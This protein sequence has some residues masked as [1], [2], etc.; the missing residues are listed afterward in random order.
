MAAAPLPPLIEIN[1][2][3][4][5]DAA[6]TEREMQKVPVVRDPACKSRCVAAIVDS[7]HKVV[8]SSFDGRPLEPYEPLKEGDYVLLTAREPERS[9]F[10]QKAS[11]LLFGEARPDRAEIIRHLIAGGRLD[12]FIV[13]KAEL[14]GD[15]QFLSNAFLPTL[16]HTFEVTG[17][18]EAAASR[19]PRALTTN[20]A[21]AYPSAPV[22]QS[23]RPAPRDVLTLRSLPED[24]VL[25][26]GELSR[27]RDLALGP[28][29]RGLYSAALYRVEGET[30]TLVALAHFIVEPR[31]P[32][33]AA[34]AAASAIRASPEEEAVMNALR[35]TA[36]AP[37]APPARSA[38]A[39]RAARGAEGMASTLGA[40][41]S[42]PSALYEPPPPAYTSE[43]KP[44]P[45][46]AVRPPAYAPPPYMPLSPTEPHPRAPGGP[47][48]ALSFSQPSS[49]LARSA[50]QPPRIM[51]PV[52][53]FFEPP[54]L[55]RPPPPLLPMPVPVSAKPELFGAARALPEPGLSIAASALPEPE[56]S[57]A[58][59][60]PSEATLRSMLLE[61]GEVPPRRR[62]NLRPRAARSPE[63]RGA[64][65]LET[66]PR[67]R[68]QRRL[69]PTTASAAALAP[70]LNAEAQALAPVAP[71]ALAP[72]PYVREEAAPIA[73][74][75]LAPAPYG[76]EEAAPI[77]P[78][79]P[80]PYGGEEAAPMAPF[81]PAVASYGGGAAAPFAIG[82]APEPVP[83]TSPQAATA[84][85]RRRR[86][87]AARQRLA[88]A[89]PAELALAEPQLPIAPSVPQR[90]PSR[91]R[92]TPALKNDLSP[93]VASI[94]AAQEP[95]Q[96]APAALPRR[97]V[98][99]PAFASNIDP[100][101]LA[102]AELAPVSEARLPGSASAWPPGQQFAFSTPAQSRRAFTRKGA[103]TAPPS[104]ARR[105]A[106]AA[107]SQAPRGYFTPLGARTLDE[108]SQAYCRCQAHVAARQ[109]TWCLENVNSRAGQTSP[110]GRKCYN[111]FAICHA[112]VRGGGNECSA[113][114]N[115]EGMPT[116]ELWAYAALRRGTE[117]RLPP[118]EDAEK[119][120]AYLVSLMRSIASK[121]T[122]P[123][124]TQQS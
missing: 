104:W 10:L 19:V 46:E 56:L 71:F 81:A 4:A 122:R 2:W 29:R 21:F 107:M 41:P 25:Y 120:R 91:P 87:A 82:A 108:R 74:F 44:M 93:F 105:P 15:G 55:S 99:R 90:R 38:A 32:P 112:S 106:V 103:D 14:L 115:W 48:S 52:A 60:A 22:L 28:G 102:A 101:A 109:D 70:S 23:E 57:G 119:H 77:A 98:R 33:S 116:D 78:F 3:P 61:V 85:R 72:A 12:S 97:R 64:T 86:A 5:H 59:S 76:R 88:E 47:F 11:D 111:P 110:D 43:I 36:H 62:R 118:R 113:Y 1:G 7:N 79:A 83:F 17:L 34:A 49:T 42:A 20:A 54:L 63:P 39:Q 95:A 8:F 26:N 37:S 51:A 9:S 6:F 65:T 45:A 94:P 66:E 92:Y 18:S 27:A 24:K 53:R 75:A 58:A 121:R 69:S 96:A 13:R 67:A 40:A 89:F 124:R 80:A 123:L 16:P 35:L 117:G 30:V 31:I 68:R 50:A 73:P 84:E 100:L 114:M